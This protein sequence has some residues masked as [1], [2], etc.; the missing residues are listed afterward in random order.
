MVRTILAAVLLG[1]L[2]GVPTGALGQ[3]E[4]RQPKKGPGGKG[5]DAAARFLAVLHDQKVAYEKNLND[6][7]LF[8]LLQ[9]LAKRYDL[10]FV[11]MDETFK[12]EDVANI[13]EAKPNLTAT[14]FQ[15]VSV[16]RFLSMVLKS[17]NAT[18]LV[19]ADY[20]E[21]TTRAAAQKEAG[22]DEAA[23]AAM[24]AEDLNAPVRAEYRLTLPLVSVVTEDQP[25]DEVI[26]KLA[27]NYDLNVVIHP[28]VRKQMKGV[29][30][31]ERL[32]NVPADDALELLA[33]LVDQGVTRKG[34]S[35]RIG[36]G[37]G[38]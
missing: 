31:S 1:G 2:V 13:R 10:T 26:L 35:F 15:G 17:V 19:R 38:V 8:E 36:V 22:L 18:Y 3:E 12:A 20:I 32:L 37:G 9:D 16:H 25:L 5:G 23:Q 11:I 27:R 34:N 24:N 7:P 6:T 33:G 28:E 14:Q 21:I 29:K 4:A 30:V